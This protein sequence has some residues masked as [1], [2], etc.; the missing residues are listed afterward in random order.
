[1]RFDLDL[2]AIGYALLTCVLG[3]LAVALLG[4]HLAPQSFIALAALIP[5]STGHMASR[6]APSRHYTHS[7]AAIT[8]AV[9]IGMALLLFIPGP[10]IEIIAILPLYIA[11]ACLG[12][13]LDRYGKHKMGV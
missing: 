1:M 11:L 8:I 2:T 4:D 13:F 3:C 5:V 6:Y 12:A 7:I 10:P 9:V